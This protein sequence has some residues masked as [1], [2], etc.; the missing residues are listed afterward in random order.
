VGVTVWTTEAVLREA[1]V[2]RW[3]PDYVQTVETSDFR[4]VALP[5]T[6]DNPTQVLRLPG[7]E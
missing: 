1:A 2:R 5:Q 7:R 4:L 6:W 3:V